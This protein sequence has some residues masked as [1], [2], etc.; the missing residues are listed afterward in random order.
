MKIEYETLPASD[1]NMILL[2]ENKFLELLDKLES[3]EKD[4]AFYRCCALSGEIP[5]AGSEPSSINGSN[6]DRSEA[7]E[8]K[9]QR[10]KHTLDCYDEREGTVPLREFVKSLIKEQ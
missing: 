4:I 8:Q 7:A 3:A 9:L 10:I 6:A 5:K 1:D 2:S